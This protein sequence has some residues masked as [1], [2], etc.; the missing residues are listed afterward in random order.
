VDENIKKKLMHG[1][2]FASPSTGRC[3]IMPS[4]RRGKLGLA[5]QAHKRLAWFFFS[6]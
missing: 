2:G 3:F 4:A 6:F 1:P 5:Y